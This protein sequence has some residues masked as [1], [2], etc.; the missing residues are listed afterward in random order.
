QRR[1]RRTVM[2]V[3]GDRQ[4]AERAAVKGFLEREDLGTRFAACVPVTACELQA[5]LDRFCAAVT[6]ERTLQAR[7]IREPLGERTLERVVE[8]I[9]RMQ[10][11]A[12]LLGDGTRQPG[13]RVAQRCDADTRQK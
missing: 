3:R 12:R 13:V 1:E 2:L 7:E 5:R 8:Q 10:Q 9:R 6:E 4:R 11:R